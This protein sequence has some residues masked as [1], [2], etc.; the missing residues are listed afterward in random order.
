MTVVGDLERERTVAS[1][2]RHFVEGRLS[3]E[4]LGERAELA[5]GA[6]S[7]SELRAVLRDLQAPWDDG[8]ERIGSAARRGMRLVALLFL[9]GVWAVMTLG[10][11]IAFAVTL[12]VFGSSI[13]VVGAFTAVWAAVSYALW[14]PWF[15]WQRRQSTSSSASLTS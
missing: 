6:R 1:L 3:L 12:V 8:V 2:R 4:D 13:A 11:A 7:R 5:L 9:A 10:L 15:R 14:R